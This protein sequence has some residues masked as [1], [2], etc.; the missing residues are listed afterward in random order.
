MRAME[1][2]ERR[3]RLAKFR[4]LG[5]LPWGCLHEPRAPG[6]GP[7]A[8]PLAKLLEEFRAEDRASRAQRR[9]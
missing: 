1:P 7:P 5:A 2:E 9:A 4:Y 3:E 8:A 6:T